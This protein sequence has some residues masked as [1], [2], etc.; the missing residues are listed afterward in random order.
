MSD[1]VTIEID[2]GWR[3][4]LEPH[5]PWLCVRLHPAQ[6][7]PAP[8]D[9]LIERLWRAIDD[10]HQR[11]VVLQKEDVGFLLS[12]L[13][14]ELVRLHKRLATQAGWLRLSGLLQACD[15]ALRT[16][17]LHEVLPI[18]ADRGAAVR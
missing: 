15:E 6:D 12:S 16:C 10:R 14:G 17:R 1:P 9:G 3:A 13:M 2:Y 11:D 5:D 4:T 18:Y 7:E 8:G